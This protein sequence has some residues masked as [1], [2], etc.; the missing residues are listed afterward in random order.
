MCPGQNLHL[1]EEMIEVFA[2]PPVPA[3]DGRSRERFGE[4]QGRLPDGVGHLFAPP[5]FEGRE[6]GKPA[7]GGR[8]SVDLVFREELTR[9]IEERIQS[10]LTATVTLLGSVAEAEHPV[11]TVAFVVG[12]FFQ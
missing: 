12:R 10:R 5:R 9:Q 11:A 3:A 1:G 4:G 2:V 8:L 6:F 7:G